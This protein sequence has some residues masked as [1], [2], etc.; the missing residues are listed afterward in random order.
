MWARLE[1]TEIKEIIAQPK[2]MIIGDT[3]YP[4]NIFNLWSDAELKGIGI[5]PVIIDNSNLKDKD[6]YNNGAESFTVTTSG[7]TK[8]T[9]SFGTASSKSLA[10]TE[11]TDPSSGNKSTVLGLKSIHKSRI[12]SQ[13]AS[14]LAEHDWMSIRAAEGGTAMPSDIKTWRANVRTKANSMC[15]QIDNAAD[16]DALAALYV[17]NDADP[18]VR[19]LGEWPSKP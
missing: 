16:V 12:N 2:G 15:T 19:P 10:D 8:V 6:Y 9:K 18:A 7:G 11:S 14:L 3:Q 13:A 5:Y 1:G 17:Y 4:V